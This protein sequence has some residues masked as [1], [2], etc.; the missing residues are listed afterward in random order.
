M[1]FVA[2]VLTVLL[3]CC[4]F[5]CLEP[6][7]LLLERIEISTHNLWFENTSHSIVFLLKYL[8]KK[9]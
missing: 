2:G 3:V 9:T 1:Q 6:I 7:H 8:M 4:Q 5:V